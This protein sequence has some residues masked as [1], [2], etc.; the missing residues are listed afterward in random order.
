MF[1]DCFHLVFTI[2]MCHATNIRI[3]FG[4]RPP[5]Q[6]TDAS[7]PIPAATSGMHCRQRLKIFLSPSISDLGLLIWHTKYWCELSNGL[8]NRMYNDSNDDHGT[9]QVGLYRSEYSSTGL[10]YLTFWLVSTRKYVSKYITVL[11]KA[12]WVGLI[13]R[14]LPR[15]NRQRLPKARRRRRCQRIVA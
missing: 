2:R 5:R 11:L 15:R 4:K 10:Q 12:R 9:R 3:Q 13:C 7:F 14:T 1:W 8:F 6:S